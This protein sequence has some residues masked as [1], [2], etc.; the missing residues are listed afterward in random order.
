MAKELEITSWAGFK[1]TCIAKKNLNC[2]FTETDT[3]VDVYGPDA[4]DILWHSAFLKESEDYTDFDTNYRAKFN[5]AIGSRP[6]AFAT[7]D[8]EFSPKAAIAT[9][10]A[11]QSESIILAMCGTKYM[12]GG[13]L[14]T[15][16]NAVLGDWIEVQVVD[17]D[18]LLQ[19]GVDFVLKSWI[20]KW[21]VDPKACMDEVVTPYAGLPPAGMY[22]RLTYHS[23]GAN[24]V[25][26]ALNLLMHKAI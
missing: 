20:D 12:N 23:T 2:Q 6:Y 1:A 22:I 13:K 9:C 8:F 15:D 3:R 24:P 5:W 17:H 11:G 4:D 10:A 16:G 19:Q 14:I 25:V 26:F 18:N 7:G 21:Y